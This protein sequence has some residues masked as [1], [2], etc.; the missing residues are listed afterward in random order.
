MK[1][2]KMKN[3]GQQEMVGFVLIVAIV[4]VGLMVFLVISLKNSDTEINSVE[5]DH[6][7]NAILKHT[8]TCAIDFEPNYDDLEDLFKSCHKGDLCKN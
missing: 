6:L 3:N 4:M 5:V 1:I 2:R 8:T 7:L